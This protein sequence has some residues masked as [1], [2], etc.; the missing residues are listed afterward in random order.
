MELNPA[1]RIWN[2]AAI[3]RGGDTPRDGDTAL[4]SLLLFHGMAMNGGIGHAVEALTR[5][6]FDAGV[7]GYQYFGLDAVAL[8]VGRAV[9]A[10]DD[11]MES[12]DYEYGALVPDDATLV[13]AFEKHLT[14]FPESFSPLAA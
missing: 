5:D 14:S 4:A 10:N 12:L 8:V 2:R 6:E 7:R 1:N 9:G 3:Q 13:A 11:E